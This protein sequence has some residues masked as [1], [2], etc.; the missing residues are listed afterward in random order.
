LRCRI[1]RKRKLFSIV[2]TGIFHSYA[3]EEAMHATGT[4]SSAPRELEPATDSRA[5]SLL[6]KQ[7]SETAHA[8]MARLFVERRRHRPLEHAR[9]EALESV[10][11]LLVHYEET[12]HR[13]AEAEETYRSLFESALIGIFR[14]SLDGRPLL[15]NES[16]ARLFGYDSSE[17]MLARVSH[18]GEHVFVDYSQW[19]ELIRR[20]ERYGIQ[21]GFEVEVNALDGTTKWVS[22]NIRSV[23]ENDRA[24]HYEGTAEDITD[25]KRAEERVRQL[26]YYDL[27]TGL[28]NRPLFEERLADSIGAAQAKS[29]RVAL[30]VLE[31][32]RFKM[33]NDSLGKVFGDR[34]L[35]EMALRIKTALGEAITVARLG[36]AEFAII[37]E[38]VKA[39]R[40]VQLVA[41]QLLA[42]IS[43]E[44]SFLGHSFNVSCTMGISMF[45]E[46]GHDSHTLLERADAAM[47]SVKDQETNG[48]QFYSEGIDTQI[49]TRLNLENGLRL[50]LERNELFLVY[51]PQIDTRT[52]GISGLE[53]LLRWQHPEMGLIPPNDFISVAES[54]GLIVP[55]G[56]WVLRTACLQARTWQDAGLPA[57]PVAVNVSAIQMRQQGFCELIRRVL[58]ETSLDAKYL[59]LELTEGLLMTNVD[60]IFTV[61]QELRELGVKL[62]IDDF[63]TG[64]SSLNYL[65]QF[66]V[67][68]LKIDR[69][70]VREVPE[71]ADDAAITTAIINMAKALNL[72]VLAEGVENVE[73]LDFLRAQNCFEIQGFYF[74]KPM[75]VDQVTQKL[76][77]SFVS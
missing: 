49:R 1:C 2:G 61:I 50:A 9:H 24:V 55:I 7:D 48:I 38:D 72:D 40:E 63:G 10:H 70:F 62:T 43:A 47:C 20:L 71:N 22:L 75:A 17:Q 69:S 28:P 41:Q 60:V 77:G 36:G 37:L 11:R 45:P 39:L 23:R 13:L 73:Q 53:A 31:L 19:Y 56:E 6:R 25:R 34:L 66:K 57:V 67:N 12:N 21:H 64:Y 52:G 68:R 58:A 59:E 14:L 54:S 35:Q 74:S 8:A 76:Q 26:A 33:I 44:F 15:A 27:V 65:R 5:A 4:G 18:V 32:G 42:T 16:A 3:D 46:H 29:Q 51:Q 30:L